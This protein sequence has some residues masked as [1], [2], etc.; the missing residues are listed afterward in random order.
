M[1]GITYLYGLWNMNMLGDSPVTIMDA[2]LDVQACLGT[3]EALSVLVPSARA[4]RSTFEL[5]S[6]AI[7]RRLSGETNEIV[8]SIVSDRSAVNC[9]S[10][11]RIASAGSRAESAMRHSLQSQGL[12]SPLP[13][14][15]LPTELH[16]LDSLFLNPLA[17][18][19]KASESTMVKTGYPK[20]DYYGSGER[21][22]ST[23]GHHT[24]LAPVTFPTFGSS[25]ASVAENTPQD[26]AFS[27]IG[28]APGFDFL[29]FLAADDG[30][31]EAN[32]QW[33]STES[34]RQDMPMLG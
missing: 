24:G 6:S 23:G 21:S 12:P 7:L 5:L 15:E 25:H 19:P 31:R 3:L 30:G 32:A 34:Y 8:D 20:M 14:L 1:A 27:E 13:K 22:V 2:H 29:S 16:M 28:S 17:P 18:H 26:L 9:P 10:G 33:L 11:A 4:C